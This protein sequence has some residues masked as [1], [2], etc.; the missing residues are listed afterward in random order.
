MFG[1]FNQDELTAAVQDKITAYR[2]EAAL[3]RQLPR[4]SVRYQTA[5]QLRVWAEVLEPATSPSSDH[6]R[7]RRV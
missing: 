5:Q 7:L 1:H 3:Q 2:L 6:R 4:Y